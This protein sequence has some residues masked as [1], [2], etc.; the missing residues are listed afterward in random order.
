M[1]KSL[2]DRI[3]KEEVP[4]L[5]ERAELMF[6]N[7]KLAILIN[8]PM[9]GCRWNSTTN[10]FSS[11]GRRYTITITDEGPVEPEEPG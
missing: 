10:K 3:T 9:K 1:K 6:K 8:T 4:T 11:M 7:L 2:Y 5:G